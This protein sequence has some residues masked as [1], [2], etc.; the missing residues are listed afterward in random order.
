MNPPTITE[1]DL[2][3]YVDNQLP[4]E[5]RADVDAYL[6]AHP[7]EATRAQAY[8]EQK[9]AIIAL[10]R[11]VLDEPIPERLQWAAKGSGA[12]PQRRQAPTYSFFSSGSPQRIAAGIIL[13]C[14]GALGGWVGRGTL[15]SN[16]AATNRGATSLANADL[17]SLPRQAAMAHRVFSPDMGRP[18]EIAADQESLLI[19]WLSKR[20]GENVRAPTLGA[21]GYNLIGGRLL[22]GAHGPVAQFMY[23]D[24][25]GQRLTLYLTN[26]NKSNTS[27]G[28]R[29]TKEDSVNV[30]YWIDG[31]F[32]YA[33]SG[34]IDKNK[35]SQLAS[36]VYQQLESQ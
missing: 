18:V 10:Y 15:E 29:F 22:P 28:F 34:G 20:L 26:D 16:S 6:A 4:D 13:A 19:K 35:L 7:G 25:A 30:F 23:Q 1:T 17:S 9:S 36:A 2:Q 3:A 8:R 27:T 24:N 12:A 32:G 33:L 5:R 14:A 11:D 31:R 21:L